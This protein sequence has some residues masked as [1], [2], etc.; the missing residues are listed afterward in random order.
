[1]GSEKDGGV[2]WSGGRVGESGGSAGGAV[3]ARREVVGSSGAVRRLLLAGANRYP[4]IEI[5]VTR[6]IAFQEILTVND[7][8]DIT[9]FPLFCRF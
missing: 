9:L 2:D 6:D 3:G 8:Q 1:M 4:Q 7:L 5:W